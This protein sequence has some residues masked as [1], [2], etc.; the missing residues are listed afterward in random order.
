MK[1]LFLKHHSHK[2]VTP[3][4]TWGEKE[5]NQDLIIYSNGENK[6]KSGHISLWV[7]RSAQH[8]KALAVP[9]PG[10]R[11]LKASCHGQHWTVRPARTRDTRTGEGAAVLNCTAAG[12]GGDDPQLPT[13]GSPM[14]FSTS[15]A[16]NL[17]IQFYLLIKCSVLCFLVNGITQGWPLK[18]VCR[19]CK[20]ES[21][22]KVCVT[23]TILKSNHLYVVQNKQ[24]P[25][26]VLSTR[27]N[28]EF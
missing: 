19:G 26:L 9:K 28:H 24:H 5:T 22:N 27:L 3:C 16:G 4:T 25:R 11:K 18:E 20:A 14:F 10:C 8:S 17:H 21:E 2:R 13:W 7:L 15:C 1:L 6:P 23:N 12:V